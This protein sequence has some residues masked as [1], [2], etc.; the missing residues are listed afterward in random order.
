M[1]NQPAT[2][3]HN[4]L[5][6]CTDIRNVN[7]VTKSDSCPL[8]HIDDCVD[9]VG[10]AKFV[11]KFDFLKGY[12]QVPLSKRDK[13]IASSVTL[14]GLCSFTV[15]PFGLKNAPATFQWLMKRIG[16]NGLAEHCFAWKLLVVTSL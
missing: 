3:L 12:W 9:S 10:L 16:V 7:V 13:E 2:E 5:R 14:S 6:V 15:M 8:R 11:S 4:T 1:L